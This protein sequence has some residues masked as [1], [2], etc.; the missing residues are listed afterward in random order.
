LYGGWEGGV[1]V[2]VRLACVT[3]AGPGWMT[4]RRFFGD[5][6]LR[7]DRVRCTVDSEVGE[8]YRYAV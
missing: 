4:V 2:V 6:L 1:G 8:E 7:V 3:L 5:W